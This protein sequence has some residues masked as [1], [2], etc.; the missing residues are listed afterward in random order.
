M[1]SL[2]HRVV[3]RERGRLPGHRRARPVAA[4]VRPAVLAGGEE[5]AVNKVVQLG[6]QLARLSLRQ[7]KV[8][9]L[10]LAKA[11]RPPEEPPAATA[12]PKPDSPR[13][14]PLAAAATLDSP[15]SGG[16]G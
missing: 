1:A 6:D 8:V 15:A 7:A 5:D 4:G 10:G 14:P 16:G 3:A 12:V 13:N 11:L 2:A 9:R